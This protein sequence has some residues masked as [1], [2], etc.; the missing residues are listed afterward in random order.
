[1]NEILFPNK[2]DIESIGAD[3]NQLSEDPVVWIKE[4]DIN[5]RY[6]CRNCGDQFSAPLKVVGQI[7]SSGKHEVEFSRSDCNRCGDT[8]TS[9]HVRPG[10]NTKGSP[11]E[12]PTFEHYVESLRYALSETPEDNDGKA[13]SSAK[14]LLRRF[15]R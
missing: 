11:F 12:P 9:P 1:M 6:W 7:R 8:N 14:K 15:N 3:S 5:V 4:R 13:I 10:T 2:S